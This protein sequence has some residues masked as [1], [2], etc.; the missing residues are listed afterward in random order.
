[1]L[2]SFSR[3][4]RLALLFLVCA[5]V[6]ALA[7]PAKPLLMLISIDGLKPQAVLEADR[8]G[9]KLPNLRALVRDGTYSTGVLGVLPT[10]TYPS[11]TTILTGAS[12]ARHGIFANTTFDPFDRNLRGWYW[13]AE[14]VKVPT[15]WDAAAAVRLRSA[16]VYWPTS[17]GAHVSY[18]LAQIWRAGTADDLKLQRAVSTPGLEGELSRAAAAAGRPLPPYPGGE[19]ESVADDEIRAQYAIRL[20][21]L[22]RP[23]FITVYLTGLDTEQHKSGPFS[24]PANAVLERIDA[25]IGA[26]RA[27]ADQAASRRATICVVS[28]HGCARIL[29]APLTAAELPPL[30]LR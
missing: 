21:V 16:N 11:H 17:V 5:P 15:L 9:L 24:A 3:L 28:D 14:D 10:L 18:N 19:D 25:I 4:F 12:P 8:N 6:P 2:H 26:L 23:D 7:A 22:K 13:Y 30:D 20:M 27:A 29:H 1:M